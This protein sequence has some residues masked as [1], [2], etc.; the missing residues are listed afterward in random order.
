MR[1]TVTVS[2]VD[3]ADEDAAR[4]VC[5]DPGAGLHPPRVQPIMRP[6]IKM[7]GLVPFRMVFSFQT[8]DTASRRTFRDLQR[9]G[10]VAEPLADENPQ[11]NQYDDDHGPDACGHADRP[12]ATAGD[13]DDGNEL[14]TISEVE[15]DVE[16]N[17]IAAERVPAES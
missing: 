5:I 7:S 2:L 15:S 8:K 3:E 12:A 4:S 17:A 14:V 13:P 1:R 10:S 16:A 6:M 9:S 11:Q